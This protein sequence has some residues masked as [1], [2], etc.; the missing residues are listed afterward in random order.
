MI[1]SYDND[2]DFAA[3]GGGNAP[4]EPIDDGFY[5]P[6]PRRKWLGWFAVALLFASFGAA[7]FTLLA[8]NAPQ[9][10]PETANLP[11]AQTTIADEPVLL[12]PSEPEGITVLVKQPDGRSNEQPVVAPVPVASGS[13]VANGYSIDLGSALSF[14]ELSLRFATMEKMNAEAAFD[15]LEPRATLRETEAG[16]EARLVVGPFAT[17]EEAQNACLAIALPASI[18]CVAVAFEGELIARQ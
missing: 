6:D 17:L 4:G 2:Q 5:A 10:P 13:Q 3:V 12:L 11:E 18:D 9:K 15:K 7:G 16:L 14:S 8:A 1:N